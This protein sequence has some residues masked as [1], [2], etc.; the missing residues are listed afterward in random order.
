MIDVEIRGPVA[1]KEYGKLKKL[2][3]TAG[4]DVVSEKRV[5]IV[6]KGIDAGVLADMEI[7]VGATSKLVLR[8][9]RNDRETVLALSSGQ[10]AQA[11]TFCASLGYMK[12]E[13]SVREVFSARYGGAQ[14]QLV[15]PL[16]DEAYYY[17]AA[18]TAHDPAGVKECKKKL[19]TLARKFKLPMWTEP[20][21]ASF[22]GALGKRSN[23]EYDFATHGANHFS[24]T[25]GI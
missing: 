20:E 19:E 22:F 12:G 4:E 24:D 10:L 9:R 8:D 16:E 18:M 13:V 7:R 15:D 23:Y 14:F 21:M 3:S 25:F 1:H 11:V 17:E 6:Y 5:S 2:L